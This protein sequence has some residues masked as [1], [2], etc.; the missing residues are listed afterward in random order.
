MPKTPET[1]TIEE[2]D[3]LLRELL[4]D[5]FP[6]WNSWKRLRNYTMSLLMLDAGLRIGEVVCSYVSEIVMAGAP[7]SALNLG[8]NHAEKGC[9]RIIPISPRL[10]EAITQMWQNVWSSREEIYRGYAFF[11]NDISKHLTTRQ[12]QRIIGSA[13]LS[14][15]GRCIHPHVLRHT[16][17]TRLMRVTSTPVVQ[18]LLGH[19]HL[20]STQVYTHPNGDD[21]KKAIEALS[22]HSI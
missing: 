20:S 9:E 16:F 1:L 11:D 17:A 22:K 18:Q 13:S 8:R 10:A 5:P 2:S 19:K 15:F 4:K 7:V 12:V 21:C 14:A 6:G 3:S